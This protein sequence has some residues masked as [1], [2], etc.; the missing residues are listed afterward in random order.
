[1]RRVI[2][3]Q[4]AV[5]VDWIGGNKLAV[6]V[7]GDVGADPLVEEGALGLVLLAVAALDFQHQCLAVR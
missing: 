1:M 5:I 6:H 3:L 7:C 4:N 2:V